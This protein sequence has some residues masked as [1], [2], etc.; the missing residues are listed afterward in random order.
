MNDG[1]LISRIVLE[2]WLRCL[3]MLQNRSHYL[4]HRDILFLIYLQHEFI[5]ELVHV[6]NLLMVIAGFPYLNN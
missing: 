1:L 4:Q 5:I 3:E 2:I 6:Q